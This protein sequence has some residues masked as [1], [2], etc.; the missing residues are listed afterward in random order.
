MRE[1]KL[2]RLIS[3]LS[4]HEKR[5]L[6]VNFLD[7]PK[8]KNLA[9]LFGVL[10]APERTPNAEAIR[11]ALPSKSY[12]SQPHVLK[13]ALQE[14]VLTGLRQYHRDKSASMR[15]QTQVLDAQVFTQKGLY[16]DAL[17]CIS[18]A[19]AESI[20]YEQF[21][22][23]ISLIQLER[24][25]LVATL[26]GLHEALSTLADEELSILEIMHSYAEWKACLHRVFEADEAVQAS[27]L[28]IELDADAPLCTK[29]VFYYCAYSVHLRDGRISEAEAALWALISEMEDAPHLVADQ[30]HS[31][32]TTLQNIAGFYIF[33]DQVAQAVAVFERLRGAPK[34]F[35]LEKDQL[36]LRQVLH[37]V[38]VELEYYRTR[39]LFVESDPARVLATRLLDEYGRDVPNDYRIMLLFQ[40]AHLHVSAHN[41]ALALQCLSLIEQENWGDVRRDIQDVCA[42]LHVWVALRQG[43][44]GEAASC[45]RSWSRRRESRVFLTNLL[46]VARL[47]ETG[48]YRFKESG[49][50]ARQFVGNAGELADQLCAGYRGREAESIRALMALDV[51]A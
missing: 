5:Y 43:N 15:V 21:G 6:S 26:G 16:H 23:T 28:A 10:S 35:G 30:P 12:K 4:Q 51:L 11:K 50:G 45:V 44:D 2:T 39:G 42:F 46:A 47:F 17:R 33:E 27:I 7:R 3:R 29:T 1:H 25:A 40:C 20:R 49:T 13:A 24:Q 37:G 14:R 22:A 18:E 38:N 8:Q 31:Y 19:K 36:P 34:R 32:F 48:T 41:D 9:A